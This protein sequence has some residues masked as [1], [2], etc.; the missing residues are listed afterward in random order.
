[1]LQVNTL[2]LAT[3]LQLSGVYVRWHDC[4]SKQFLEL[5]KTNGKFRPDQTF[6][7]VMKRYILILILSIL[8]V[9]NVSSYRRQFVMCTLHRSKSIWKLPRLYVNN[10]LL[11]SD[12]TV[13]LEEDSSH[14]LMNVMRLKIG[15]SFRAFNGNDGEYICSI[16]SYSKNKKSYVATF[17]PSVQVRQQYND[18]TLPIV[19][20]CSLIK[21]ARLKIL[22]EKVTE[23]GISK[24]VFVRTQNCNIDYNEKDILPG[25]QRICIE[26]AEQCERLSIPLLIESIS[27][28]NL[29][30]HWF[31]NHSSSKLLVRNDKS[32]QFT[33]CEHDSKILVCRERF[34]GGKP[35]LS[36]LNDGVNLTLLDDVTNIGVFVGPE[37]GFSSEELQ[38]MSGGLEDEKS[39]FQFVTL[40]S[41]VLRAE[42]AAISAISMISGAIDAANYSS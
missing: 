13:T 23:L 10:L 35:L 34:E 41:S 6:V 15:S 39:A 2:I 9:N 29:A 25:L 28:Q 36:A 32:G 22:L 24:I 4:F 12:M 33:N 5:G 20:Y 42:T 18:K 38:L 11:K 31:K 3:E 37:G 40:G 16:S 8:R 27:I 26:S 19:L 21:K 7:F 17:V 1:M 14:Y 30:K